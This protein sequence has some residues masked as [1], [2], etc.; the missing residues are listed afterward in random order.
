[1]HEI[2]HT[3]TIDCNGVLREEKVGDAAI[4]GK[5]KKLI[6]E[7]REIQESRISVQ[8]QR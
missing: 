6:A 5:L 8:D 4:E 1:V 2:P 3:F 7:A